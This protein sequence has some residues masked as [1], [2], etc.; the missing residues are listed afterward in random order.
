[1]LVVVPSWCWGR[2]K[3]LS[4]L[5]TKGRVGACPEIIRSS[6]AFKT[7]FRRG[8]LKKSVSLFVWL[9]GVGPLEKTITPLLYEMDPLSESV[10]CSRVP[11]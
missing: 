10:F 6:M 4:K 2:E 3:D 7:L 8:F 11:L 1:M 5:S 9:L